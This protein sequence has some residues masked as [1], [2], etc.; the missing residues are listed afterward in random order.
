MLF[1]SCPLLLRVYGTFEA[2][3]P[4]RGLVERPLLDTALALR[5]L[6]ERKRAVFGESLR[7]SFQSKDGE[8]CV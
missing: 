3:G 8:N 2:S 4:D 7:D 6:P 5:D 1:R